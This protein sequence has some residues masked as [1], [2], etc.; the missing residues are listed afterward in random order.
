MRRLFHAVVCSLAR[1]C[2]RSPRASRDLAF[3]EP[4]AHGGDLG[5]HR[6]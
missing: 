4:A 3:I 2:L 1:R 5:G 6:P